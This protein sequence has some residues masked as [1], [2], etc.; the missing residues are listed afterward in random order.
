[1]KYLKKIILKVTPK[2]I[3]NKY[4]NRYINIYKKKYNKTKITNPKR[5]S[6]IIPNYNYKK[7]LK[8][9]IDS[10]LLQTYPIYEIIIL[11]DCSTDDS[12]SLIKEIISKNKDFNIKLI[13]NKENSGSVFNQWKKG[14]ENATGDY[15]WIAEADDS[16]HPKFLETV[17]KP[18]DDDDVVISYCE[19]MRIDGNNLILNK[20][21]RDWVSVASNTKWNNS[22]INSGE[23]EIK[24]TLSILNTI[25]NVSAVV[26]K[27]D[28]SKKIINILEKA[29]QFKMSGDWFTY[30]SI[31]KDGKIAY[32][33]KSL[34]YF[35]RHGRSTCTAVS[36]ERELKEVL[37]IQK[38]IREN[39]ELNSEQLYRQQIRYA[40]MIDQIS[41]DIQKKYKNMM[42]VKVKWIFNESPNEC[43]NLDKIMEIANFLVKE[44]YVCDLY[45]NEDVN[46]VNQ[47]LSK[48]NKNIYDNRLFEIYSINDTQKEYDISIMNNSNNDKEDNNIYFYSNS[49]LSNKKGSN[50]F[51]LQNNSL[52]QNITM[53]KNIIDKQIN[54]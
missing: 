20:E 41:K 19:S 11:D 15:V 12:V 3:Y 13:E 21:C 16:C 36:R 1:M 49:E 30:Y 7:Y 48:I 38:D 9:R 34:N 24:E 25:L 26:F 33:S 35:R 2:F 29:K 43:K 14:F 8:E 32:T 52:N 44:R 4:K 10:I 23:K 27:N 45:F 37:M 28:D 51:V 6:V 18:F 54:K 17:I 5:I 46:V 53:L 40:F 31:L 42:V 39:Y 47:Q 50:V 22:Y